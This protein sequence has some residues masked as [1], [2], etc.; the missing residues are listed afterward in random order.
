MLLCP[1]GVVKITDFGFA[2]QVEDGRCR[3]PCGSPFY[4]APELLTAAEY[5]GRKA[6]IW[7][8][9]VVLFE[10]VTGGIPWRAR[11]QRELMAQIKAAAYRVPSYVPDA[12]RDLI[13]NMMERDV[14]LRFDIV[15]VLASEWVTGTRVCRPLP[16]CAEIIVSLKKIA[17]VFDGPAD[18]TQIVETALR[19]ERPLSARQVGI[20]TVERWM[21]KRARQQ[22][23][24]EGEPDLKVGSDL[25]SLHSDVVRAG[26]GVRHPKV[27]V[28][29]VSRSSRFSRLQHQVPPPAVVAVAGR[30]PILQQPL[31]KPRSNRSSAFRK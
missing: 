22:R 18:E 30:S 4:I 20:E 21:A 9:G 3:T 31:R 2:R 26:R 29:R 27:L 16:G 5:D 24:E 10:L 23:G 11:T 14:E 7:S 1:G 25:P 28:P 6:D 12:A 8:L 17:L 15:D 13:L 19:W